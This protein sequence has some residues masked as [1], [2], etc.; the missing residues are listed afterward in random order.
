MQRKI[1]LSWLGL[2]AINIHK[3]FNNKQ[4]ITPEKLYFRDDGTIPNSKY[5]L[6]L[7]KSAF[8]TH[9]DEGASWLEQHFAANNWTNSWRN[10]VCHSPATL[11]SSCNSG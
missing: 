7:Y 8:T 1:F 4:M 2:L 9:G 11:F 3:P 5:P 10:G 6:L